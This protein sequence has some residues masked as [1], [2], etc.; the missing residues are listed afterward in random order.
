MVDRFGDSAMKMT[1][2]VYNDFHNSRVMQLLAG[3]LKSRQML[4]AN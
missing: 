4:T 1:F 3:E 2:I